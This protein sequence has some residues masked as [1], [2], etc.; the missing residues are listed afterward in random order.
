MSTDAA[1]RTEWHRFLEVTTYV[2]HERKLY[3]ASAP[4]Y[5]ED[6]DPEDPDRTQRLT[7][8]ATK[9]LVDH[10]IKGIISF[11]EYR[12]KT[13]EEEM[14]SDNNIAYLHLSVEDRHAPTRGQLDRAIEFYRSHKSTL[15]HCGYGHGRTGTGVTA[16]QI[17]HTHGY[18]HVWKSENH[19]EMDAQ[20]DVLARLRNSY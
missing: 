2:H 3:R 18:E 12:Y 15:I 7:K 20:V 16:L 1:N 6:L 17:D 4:N 11:N 19:V 5:D 10:D 13:E 9:F 14:L 8:S